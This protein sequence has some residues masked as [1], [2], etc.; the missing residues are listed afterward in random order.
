MA[1]SLY[2]C[3]SLLLVLINCLTATNGRVT[4]VDEVC[5]QTSDSRLCILALGGPAAR[6]D[7]L[8]G[9]AEIGF[10]T[11]GIGSIRIQN[12]FKSYASLKKA[13]PDVIQHSLQ[14]V[15]LYDHVF[16]GLVAPAHESA[17]LGRWADVK[18]T[19]SLITLDVDNC[20]KLFG[21]FSPAHEYTKDVRVAVEAI[22]IIA[23]ILSDK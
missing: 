20:E 15:K 6:T 18:P 9:A 7:T 14:C 11:A 16:N 22:V 23:K 1:L 2:T 4:P 10:Q 5:A 13:S 3:S 19:A 21:N 17:R 12:I 8:A